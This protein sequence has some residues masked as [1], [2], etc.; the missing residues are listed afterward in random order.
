MS[1]DIAGRERQGR[2]LFSKGV[3]FRAIFEK[4]ADAMMLIKDKQFIDIN[5][6][7]LKLFGC[8]E[9][10]EIVGRGTDSF[11]PLTQPDG[12]SSATKLQ[13]MCELAQQYG[14]HRF[15]WMHLN[16]ERQPFW[17]EELFTAIQIG[18]EVQL[19]AV[20]RDIST[21]K[22]AEQSLR[23]AAHVFEYGREGIMI[24]D[25][26]HKIVSVNR[27]F[28]KIT[29]YSSEEALG[30]TPKMLSSGSHDQAFYQGL[31][32]ALAQDDHWEGEI[33]DRRRNGELYPLWQSITVVRDASHRITHCFSIFS[34][35]TERKRAEQ[36]QLESEERFRGAF[37]TAAIGMALV[38]LDG[39]W[40]KVNRSLCR[41]IGYSEQELR[42]MTFQNITHPDD[43]DADLNY[44]RQL[45][46]GKIDHF[47]ME[48]RYFHK[49]GHIV[50]ILLSVSLVR[51]A[52]GEPVHFVSQ[53]IDITE[54]KEEEARTRYLAEHDLLT[55]LPSRALLLDRLRQAIA[56]AKRNGSQLAI[57][58]IDLD[59]FKNVND[60]M[61][62][63]IG[64]K[65]LQEIA[66]RLNQHVRSVDTVSR[67]GGDEFVIMLTDIGS[68][69]QA[70]HVAA[71][72]MRA[73][74]LPYRFD[75]Y[76]FNITST[77]G[78][79]VYPTDGADMD[80]LIKNADVAMYHAKESGRNRYQFFSR[81]MN[82]R[83]VERFALENKL[84]KALIR[85]EFV[86][87]YQPET[88]IVTGRMIGAEALIRWQQPDAG[89]LLPAH[90]MAVAEECGLIV[91]IGDWVL[92]TACLQAKSWHEQGYPL[93]VSV[94]LSVAQFRQKNLLQ[95][96]LDALRCADLAPHYLEL[97]ITEGILIDGADNTIATLKALRKIGV[98]LAIDDFGTGYSSLSY[99]KRFS[100]DKLKIDQSFV[101][102][103]TIDPDGATIIS[104]IIA[105][106][107]NLKLK[108]IAEGVET[109][110]Q[111]HFLEAH[112]CDEYQGFYASE[113][114]SSHDFSQICAKN[115]GLQA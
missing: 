52:Q 78:I 55:G 76:E 8:I 53:I 42:S 24:T 93:I 38:G 69:A 57:L 32:A 75:N 71:N 104:A 37:E 68:A 31:S 74:A 72:V 90:F 2:S 92:R 26:D 27:A 39:Q 19:Y 108:V 13:A 103:M 84:R 58:F 105:M 67:Q 109:V 85:H 16:R 17:V 9:K 5:P 34:D 111:F 89:L 70:A 50:W 94:N 86:L 15:E 6:A 63:G 115:L 66:R 48:K 101:H 73:I 49:D 10:A 81:E 60:S 102:D 95:S 96:I 21:R 113:A 33:W 62:H 1:T 106:A 83:I 65:L 56:S 36:A 35:I 41:I 64:D 46:A 20:V 25:Q 114:L 88:D 97:E 30:N 12:Q 4:S 14:N 91:P 3:Y 43:I 51:N 112:G 40:L 110:E 23:L 11:S 47:R 79:S 100:V 54:H 82:T 99:L 22:A 107:K 44:V 80:T 87:Q 98:K 18:G 45:L 77:I 29:G 61:G 59:R 7:A 28:T